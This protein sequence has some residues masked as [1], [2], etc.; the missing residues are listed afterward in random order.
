MRIAFCRVA[1]PHHFNVDPDP[2]FHLNVNPDLTFSV[3]VDPD[4]DPASH[5]SDANLRPL[6]YRLSWD[7]FSLHASIVSVHGPPRPRFES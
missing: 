5:Q 6:V 3:N 2:F 4:P 1:D 7:A